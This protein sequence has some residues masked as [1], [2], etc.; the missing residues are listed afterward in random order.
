[1]CAE[2]AATIPSEILGSAFFAY[3]TKRQRVLKVLRGF[4]ILHFR[5]LQ[6]SIPEYQ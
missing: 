5:R 3:G 4:D 2:I 6:G 1:M